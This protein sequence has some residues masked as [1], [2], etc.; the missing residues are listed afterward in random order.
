M[1]RAANDDDRDNLINDA[2]QKALERFDETMRELAL[3]RYTEFEQELEPQLT[4]FAVDEIDSPDAR[5]PA[6]AGLADRID[7]E[8]RNRPTDARADAEVRP[9]AGRS[10]RRW[11]T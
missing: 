10:T 1:Q 9:L 2:S 11:K 6:I 8:A 4:R 3:L 5:T 7:E